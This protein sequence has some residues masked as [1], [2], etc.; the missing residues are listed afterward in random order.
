MTRGSS[1]RVVGVLAL[2]TVLVGLAALPSGA[3]ADHTQ[4]SIFQDDQYLL[5]EPPKVVVDTAIVLQLLGVQELRI[6]VKWSDIAPHPLSRRMPRHFTATDPAAY[7]AANWTRY[8]DVVKVAKELGLRVDFDVTAPGPL[9]AMRRHPP[10][11]KAADHWYP[12]A[13][14]FGAFVHALGVRYSGH[15]DGLPAVSDWSIWNEPDQPGWLAPQTV[16]SHGRTVAES[17]QLYRGLVRSAYRALRATD[18]T[19][20]NG[21]ILVGELAPEG[22]ETTGVYVP[23]TPMPFLRDLYCVS[24]RYRPLTGA[25]ASAL[26]CPR[27]A[28]GRRAFARGN[29]GLFRATGFSH[30]PYYFFEPPSHVAGDP[31]FVPIADIGRLE[32]GLDRAF[33]AWHVRRRIPIYFTEYGYQTKPPDPYQVVT[34]AE[35]AIYLNEADYMAWSNPRVRSMAQFELVDSAPNPNYKRSE[36]DYWDT[37]QTGLL[38]LSGKPKPAYTAYRMP[39]WIPHPHARRGHRILVW[40]QLRPADSGVA[41]TAQVQWASSANGT[42]TTLA[43]VSVAGADGYFTTHVAPPGT[44]VIR[45]LWQIDGQSL[46]SRDAPVSVR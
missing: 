34:P 22:D 17:P 9:W 28:G 3:Q 11:A 37:F 44:G 39:L 15:Y 21:T 20:A 32:R 13:A 23:M 38:Y 14:D 27:S 7:P 31:N 29:P 25:A 35:Q 19:P 6:T 16:K 40:G 5:Y 42:F 45:I 36:F 1:R 24:G 8:D 4:I 46:T 41:E 18:H 2:L 43:D 12:D 26:A 30:H 10:T 33:S